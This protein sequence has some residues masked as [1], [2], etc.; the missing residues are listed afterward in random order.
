MAFPVSEERIAAAE[1]QLGTRL[2]AEHR[3]R[4]LR[5][6]G[7]GVV[8]EEDE[9]QLHPVWDDTNRRTIARTTSH[10]VHETLEARRWDSFPR[11]AIAIASDGGGNHLSSSRIGRSRTWSYGTTRRATARPW[12]WTGLERQPLAA[13]MTT[14]ADGRRRPSRVT[15]PAGGF[16]RSGGEHTRD[17]LTAGVH[18]TETF[19]P[20]ASRADSCSGEI[21]HPVLPGLLVLIAI[22]VEVA[23]RGARDRGNGW[24]VRC[25]LMTSECPRRAGSARKALTVPPAGGFGRSGGA[26]PNEPCA[27]R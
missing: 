18:D 19:Q 15:P 16:G 1:Q 20:R 24:G 4:L 26:P 12:R 22:Q 11:D 14:D 9:W 10:V 6:N 27:P 7:G 25:A 13:R 2:L 8:C 3:A 23:D 17:E 5:D 21:H